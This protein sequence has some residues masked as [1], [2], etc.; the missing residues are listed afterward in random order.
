M[1]VAVS[2]CA[3]GP[4]AGPAPVADEGLPIGRLQ[5]GGRDPST[6]ESPCV[7][8]RCPYRLPIL[9]GRPTRPANPCLWNRPTLCRSR[10]PPRCSTQALPR[11]RSNGPHDLRSSD[12]PDGSVASWAVPPTRASGRS[13]AK[14]RIITAGRVSTMVFFGFAA[15]APS[16][17]EVRLR[18]GLLWSGEQ[19]RHRRPPKSPVRHHHSQECCIRGRCRWADRGQFGSAARCRSENVHSSEHGVSPTTTD[20]MTSAAAPAWTFHRI[21]TPGCRQS[22]GFSAARWSIA[23]AQVCTRWS[24]PAS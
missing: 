7:R 15:I 1:P 22:A 4:F 12:Q 20:R 5:L 10:T 14:V 18:R 23:T 13:D 21:R 17:S 16:W 6:P 2:F 19:H 3:A 11:G 24:G 9:N 8:P